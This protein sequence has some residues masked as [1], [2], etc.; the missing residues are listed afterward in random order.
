MKAVTSKNAG[1]PK[2]KGAPVNAS[3]SASGKLSLAARRRQEL[4]TIKETSAS[5][6]AEKLIQL[7]KGSNPK[8]KTLRPIHKKII[9]L[10]IAGWK[11][12]DIAE[13]CNCTPTQVS[14]ILRTEQAKEIIHLHDEQL[15]AEFKRLK[16]AANDV[17]R[18]CMDRDKP[19]AVRLKA[20]NTFLKANGDFAPGKDSGS[21]TAEDVVARILERFASPA[22]AERAETVNM[23]MQ[24]NINTPLKQPEDS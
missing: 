6:Y 4:A 22:L 1:A 24:V 13:A 5:Y 11:N 10:H 2:I 19:D 17:L 3:A 21:T 12:L 23:N 9:A 20:V 18:D 14:M 8:R 7:R 16:S 15:E